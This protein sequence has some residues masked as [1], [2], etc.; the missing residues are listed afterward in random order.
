MNSYQQFIHQSRYARW[1]P[2]KQRRETWQETVTRYCDFFQDRVGMS[3]QERSAAFSVIAGMNVMPSMRC[4][5]TA[6]TALE[7]DHIAGYNCAYT[8]IDRV[9]AFDEILYILMNGTGVGFSVERQYIASLPI[10]PA[11]RPTDYKIVVPDERVGW[12]RSFRELLSRLYAGEIP[13]WDLSRLRPAGTPLKTFGGRASGPGPL[14]DLFKFSVSLFRGAQGRKLTSI[15]CHDLVCKIAEVIVSGGV[16]R[17]ALLSLSN[18]SDDR[19]RLAKSGEW[20]IENQQRALANNSIAFTERPETGVFMQEWMSLYLS[21]SGERGLFNRVAARQQV[22]RIGRRN[23][24]WEW[25]T[26]P[27]SE[28]ILRPRQFCNLSEVVVRATDSLSDLLAKVAMGSTF[29]TWQSALTG[30]QYISAE[31]QNNCEDERLLGVSLTGALEHLVLNGSQGFPKLRDWLREM[32]RTAIQENERWAKRLGIE[33]S[34]A[35]TCVKPS[36]TVSQLVGTPSGIHPAHSRFYRRTV[37]IDGKD[38]IGRFLDAR[39]FPNEPDV[40]R[41]DHVRVFSFPV[42]MPTGTALQ[43]LELWRE[44]QDHWCEHKPSITVTVREHEWPT[45]GAWVWENFDSMSGVSF[46]P[47]SEHTYR[48]APYQELTEAEYSAE[49]AKMPDDPDWAALAEFEA[50]DWTTGSRE[51][52]CTADSCEVVDVG[53]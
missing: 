16:R 27:C 30:F 36:G 48:Q 51:L 15:E 52:A 4:L 22:E 26:N 5:M 13:G 19:M 12:A 47:H 37:R 49:L 39:G 2:E 11:L 40:T 10:V 46:L 17:S 43:H 3:R 20:W 53:A 9:E 28:I 34:K 8:P 45:V 42:A 7:R 18:L 14:D 21:R 35:I 50:G 23:P 33:P 41:P 29:G 25:G 31:W 6:G 1:I 44:Y 32:K 38:P 24:N